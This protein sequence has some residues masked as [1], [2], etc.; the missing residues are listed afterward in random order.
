MQSLPSFDPRTHYIEW[1]ENPTLSNGDWVLGVSVIAKSDE[2]IVEYDNGHAVFMRERRD[3]KLKETDWWALSDLSIT[4]EQ[5]SYRQA[6]RDI[7]D[8][9][10]WPWIDESDWPTKP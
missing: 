1:D 4:T 2:E 6:L 3:E 9:V 7:T 8:H 10:N 5:A